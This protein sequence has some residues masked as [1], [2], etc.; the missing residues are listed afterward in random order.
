MLSFS[1]SAFPVESQQN[2]K[3]FSD[4][5]VYASVN[6]DGGVIDFGNNRAYVQASCQMFLLYCYN[7]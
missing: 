1:F 5:S 4:L 2:E 7:A 6:H 3:T